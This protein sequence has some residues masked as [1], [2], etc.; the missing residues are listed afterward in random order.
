MTQETA[1]VE[2]NGVKLDVDLRYAKRVDTLRVGSKVKLLHKGDS[3]S[4]TKV[5]PGAVVG[6]EPFRDLPT[7]IVCYL[8]HDY[9]SN[10]KLQFAY[11][12][13]DT[14]DKY[15]I[16]AS[17]DEELPIQKADV[18]SQFD[19]DIEKARAEIKDLELK[20]QFFLDHFNQYF[21]VAA[22][23]GNGQ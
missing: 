7:I 2:V 13:S 15:D 16:V 23:G 21:E 9:S 3:Y 11:V 12:N 10:S 1:Q 18:L 17:I 8:K 6:F 19:R 20:R 4:G 22:V 5:Y 14:N